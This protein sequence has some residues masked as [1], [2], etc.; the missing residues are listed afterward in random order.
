LGLTYGIHSLYEDA[1][2]NLEPPEACHPAA[3]SQRGWNPYY[4]SFLFRR[5]FWIRLFRRSFALME[6]IIKNGSSDGNRSAQQEQE[7]EQE[8]LCKRPAQQDSL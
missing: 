2:T 7:Q 6:I 5:P 1:C 3:D 4:F 8:T